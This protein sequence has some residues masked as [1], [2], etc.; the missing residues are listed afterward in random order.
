GR[1]LAEIFGVIPAGQDLKHGLRPHQLDALMPAYYECLLRC[2]PIYSAFD[3]PDLMGRRVNYERLMLPFGAGLDVTFLLASVK[4][5]SEDG[6]FVRDS[7]MRQAS[8]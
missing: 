2:R 8:L 3:L 4:A 1:R 6:A 7:L 5:I